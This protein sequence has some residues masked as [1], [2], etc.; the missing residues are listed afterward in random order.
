M[1]VLVLVL[2]LMLMPVLVRVVVVG[3]SGCLSPRVRSIQRGA[4]RSGHIS[5]SSS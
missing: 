2:V 4:T 3:T 1:L 5:K